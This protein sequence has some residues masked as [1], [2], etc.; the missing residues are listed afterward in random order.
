MGLA[1]FRILLLFS[2]ALVTAALVSVATG[3][4]FSPSLTTQLSALYFIPVNMVCLV[5][6]RRRL[7][8]RGSTL[9]ALTG[10]DRANLARDVW[11]G[12]LWLFALFVP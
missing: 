3:A 5:L 6:L 2:A 10:F 7:R 12:L 1:G 9:A 8:A 11:Q 4:P